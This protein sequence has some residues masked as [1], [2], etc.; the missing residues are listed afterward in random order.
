MP[1]TYTTNLGIEK[2][3]SGEQSGAWGDTTN[4]NWDIVDASVN[5]ILTKTLA[6]AGSSG[7]PTVLSVSDG[8]VSDGHNAFIEFVD[9][10]DLGATAFVQLAPNNAEKIAYI[11]NSLSGGQDLTLF[12]GT[13]NAANDYVVANGKDAV[14]R[15][16]GGGS[17]A[18]VSNVFLDL[19]LTGVDATTLAVSGTLTATGTVDFSGA[20]VSD[21]G[22]VSTADINGGTADSVVIGGTIPAAGTFTTVTGTTYA[23]LPSAS[24]TVEGIVE[25]ATQAEVDAGTDTARYIT[26]ETLTNFAGLSALTLSGL[27][28]TV[29][30]SVVN[31]D[32]LQW[33]GTDWVNQTLFSA[34]I[35][36]IASPTFTGTTT[37]PAISV[38]SGA[39]DNTTVGVSTPAAGTFTTVTALVYAG[40]PD[41]SS[42]VQGVVELATQAEVDAGADA[43]RAVTPDTL[44]N[45][46]GNADSIEL[47]TDTTIT[48]VAD[49]ELLQ[50]D[51]ATGK[52]VNRTL[53]TAGVAPVAS[54]TFTG[55][56]TIPSADINGGVIDGTTIGATTPSPATFSS[57]TV[58]GS[59]TEAVYALTGTT[60]TVLAANG[61]IQTWVLSS[62]STV[63][64]GLL[65]GESVTLILEPT[66]NFNQVSGVIT[67]PAGI[68]WV[69]D[70]NPQPLG[71][72]EIVVEMFKVGTRLYGVYAGEVTVS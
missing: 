7:S 8:V 40:L 19:A 18:V 62:S 38:S 26:P 11:R 66:N 65:S 35:A 15:F 16:D 46:A 41:A 36:P 21:L 39:I 34:G 37:I 57:L 52:W 24:A 48:A 58:T 44:S 61:T 47:L 64:E 67:W 63:S 17:G 2:V 55:V 68:R 54:A 71:T 5:G 27:D 13:Y 72:V 22:A 3:A 49:N 1:S 23:G 12:Q 10:G 28:D 30:T 31:G 25:T 9:G 53:A 60:P 42:V 59:V 33:T 70:S 69:G 56:T 4:T 14:V 51:N 6:S 20:T 43:V 50:F 32:V 29:I 45:W